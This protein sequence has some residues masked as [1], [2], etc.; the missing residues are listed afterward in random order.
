MGVLI[1]VQHQ[2]LIIVTF[3]TFIRIISYYINI[4]FW[5]MG[6]EMSWGGVGGPSQ[7]PAGP[8][9]L[10]SSPFPKGWECCAGWGWR[11]QPCQG[12]CVL[13]A[14]APAPPQGTGTGNSSGTEG[15]QD[16]DNAEP[17]ALGTAVNRMEIYSKGGEKT[18]LILHHSHLLVGKIRM[19]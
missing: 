7:E 9:P 3:F 4:Y 15:E 18:L 11:C 16:R 8:V 2:S 10:P 6:C 19:A 1:P 12:S 17:P 13:C 5:L 14:T